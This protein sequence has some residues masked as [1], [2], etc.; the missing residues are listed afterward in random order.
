MALS[1]PSPSAALPVP[2]PAASAA[3]LHPGG[4]HFAPQGV[5]SHPK[6]GCVCVCVSLCAPGGGHFEPW[7]Q[8]VC[9]SAPPH[10]STAAGSSALGRVKGAETD[11]G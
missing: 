7:G 8:G 11:T 5:T 9:H 3:A 1:P 4:G 10:P 6:G 2:A